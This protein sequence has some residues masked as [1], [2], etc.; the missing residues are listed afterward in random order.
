[1]ARKF[2]HSLAHRRCI[3]PFRQVQQCNVDGCDVINLM[4]MSI[5]YAQ[6]QNHTTVQNRLGM[7][8]RRWVPTI[9]GTI[10]YQTPN[11]KNSWDI[12]SDLEP[13]CVEHLQ[14]CCRHHCVRL[15]P[16]LV[17]HDFLPQVPPQLVTVDE[18]RG[19][20]L[21]HDHKI[22]VA[23]DD[24][25]FISSIV[26]QMHQKGEPPPKKTLHTCLYGCHTPYIMGD[27]SS[28]SNNHTALNTYSA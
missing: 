16:V 11:L 5:R 8:C 4:R 6:H 17:N 19:K 14:P 18:N 9:L 25:V 10:T 15:R 23:V 7:M 3:V 1:M 2:P 27:S 20:K 13:L 22:G 24:S 26:H 28:K 12:L 21:F